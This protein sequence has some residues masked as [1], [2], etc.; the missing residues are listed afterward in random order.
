[1]IRI[2]LSKVHFKKPFSILLC[3]VSW[4]FV[5]DRMLFVFGSDPK[6][7]A[8]KCQSKLGV[9]LSD[10]VLFLGC[11][12][13]LLWLPFF[14]IKSGQKLQGVGVGVGNWNS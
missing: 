7:E 5:C 6:V 4:L 14:C 10:R 11:T 3:G 13:P 2:P 8:G 12:L 1:M 9:V